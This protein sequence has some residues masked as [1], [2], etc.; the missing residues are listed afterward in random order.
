MTT[1]YPQSFMNLKLKSVK[2]A[3]NEEIKKKNKNIPEG[4]VRHQFLNLL[5]KVAIDKY[6][7]ITKQMKNQSEAVKYSFDNHYNLALVNFEDPQF[8]RKSRYYNEKV[9]NFIQAHL[10]LLNAIYK[11]WSTKKEQGKKEKV[12]TIDDFHSLVNVLVGKDCPVRET[13]LYFNQSISLQ[14][15]EIDFDRHYY[16]LL[17]EFLECLCRVVDKASPNESEGHDLITKLD[18]IK[19]KFPDLI[20]Q[21]Q[22]FKQVKEKFGLPEKKEGLYEFDLNSHFYREILFPT[23]DTGIAKRGSRFGTLRLM[24]GSF[25][26][27]LKLK[28]PEEGDKMIKTTTLS[29]LIL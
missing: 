22:E 3:D 27:S 5:V 24:E 14:E 17:P 26:S 25:L 4:I 18:F 6:V 11:S 2:A 21:T 15:N 12:M 1:N 23:N 29:S 8:W 16:I 9:D 19:F 7:S 20:N 28:T 10:P 13:D